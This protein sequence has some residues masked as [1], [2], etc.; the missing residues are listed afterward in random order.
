M[1]TCGHTMGTPK[2][3]AFEAM[4]LFASIGHDG[5][6]FR[7]AADGQID[8]DAYTPALGERLRSKADAFGIEI[9]CLTP[10]YKNYVDPA[11]R[12]SEMQGMRHMVDIAADLG[13]TRLR[14]YG[15]P[16]PTEAFDYDTTWA[17]TAVGIREVADYAAGKGVTIC[18]ETHIGSLTLTAAETVK[19]AQAVDRPN[20]GILFDYA[21]IHYAAE[22]Q[23]E[24]AVELCAPYLQHCHVKDWSYTTGDRDQRHS[25][26][27]GEGDVDWPVALA[28]LKRNGYDGYL[29]DE[30]E[31]YWYDH[32]PEPQ[33][34]MKHNREYVTAH[35]ADA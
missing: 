2:M 24:A 29:S 17:R 14:S 18:I 8:P 6:E 23:A 27:M 11:K 30:Y 22:E 34:G 9:A 13:C 20:V 25:E 33:V 32:L 19:M 26:L 35:W 28:A 4:E 12:E 10:Y 1:K 7:C 15:G 3:D 16:M 5:I 21:W 31:K